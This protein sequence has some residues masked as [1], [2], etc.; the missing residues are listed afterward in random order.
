MRSMKKLGVLV[1]V[2]A[3]SAI[4]AANASAAT[5]TASA[6]GEL[7]GKALEKQVFTFNGG[8]IECSAAAISGTIAKTADTQW[9]W[10]KQ[11]SICLWNGITVHVAEITLQ[12]TA[13]PPQLHIKAGFTFTPTLFGASLC[14]VTIGSQTVGSVDYANASA[15]T[16]K[17]TPT[18]TGI[19]YTSTGGSCG[20]SGENGTYTGALEISR[21]GG[22]SVQ[23]DA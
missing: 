9:H 3:L 18:V 10:K 19:K 6:T 2:F 8:Q 13:F 23:Y 12:L 17:V 15:S 7:T 22:G 20:S 11:W 14:T 5:F 16:V 1:A 4:G 21:V